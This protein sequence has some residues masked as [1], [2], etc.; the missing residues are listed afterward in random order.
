[1]WLILFLFSCKPPQS[2]NQPEPDIR[3]RIVDGY[4]YKEYVHSDEELWVKQHF[5]KG[6][7]DLGLK[8]AAEELLAS[9]RKPTL[10]LTQSAANWQPIEVVIR[11]GSFCKN[12][13]YGEFS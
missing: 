8:K 2:Y 9:L 5:S 4:Y 1:M 7:V 12:L 6:F 10:F 13:K 11:S 3:Y